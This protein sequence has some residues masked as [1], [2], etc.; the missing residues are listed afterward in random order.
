MLKKIVTDFKKFPHLED[1]PTDKQKLLVLRALPVTLPLS[2]TANL[3]TDENYW[4]RCCRD[5]WPLLLPEGTET[6]KQVFFENHFKRVI[7]FYQPTEEEEPVGSKLNVER[8]QTIQD[9]VELAKLTKDYIH[10]LSIEQLLPSATNE[11]N[12]DH[13]SL[14]CILPHLENLKELNVTF[15]VRNCGMNFEWRLFDCT[16]LAK[17]ILSRASTLSKIALTRSFLK[18]D[19]TR[20]FCAYMLKHPNLNELDLSRNE[21]GD[22]GARA[23][24][25]LAFT[26]PTLKVLKLGDNKV[27]NDGCKALAAAL[28]RENCSLEQ[29]ELQLNSFNDESSSYLFLALGRNTKLTHLNVASN[30]ISEQ[31]IQQFCHVLTENKTLQNLDLSGNEFGVQV[32][33]TLQEGLEMNKTLGHIDIRLTGTG[34]ENLYT[35]QNLVESNRKSAGN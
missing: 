33:R 31:S 26:L 11:T 8:P 17:A 35:I 34:A 5:R 25:K 3:I 18:C 1:L 28:S 32:G 12:N 2:V 29:L 19:L 21:I 4:K 6:W 23:C 7:E 30:Q 15:Q 22:R 14:E 24:A 10:K 16:K 27:G 13:I 9:I 20:T